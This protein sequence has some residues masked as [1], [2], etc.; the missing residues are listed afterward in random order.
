MEQP[1]QPKPG[2]P[3]LLTQPKFL[4]L[5]WK[6]LPNRNVLYFLEKTDLPSKFGR[7]D[8]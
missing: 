8:S 4:I 6:S 1:R 5:P 7:T 3:K 2:P